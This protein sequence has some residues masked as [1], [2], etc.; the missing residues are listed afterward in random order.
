MLDNRNADS[1]LEDE[2]ATKVLAT[3][4]RLLK[5]D[6][7]GLDDNFFDSGGHSLLAM[8]LALELESELGLPVGLDRIFGRP[9]VRELCASL[10]ESVST[11]PARVLL[12]S[13]ARASH[14]IYFIHAAF[15][16]SALCEALSPD[17][18]TSFVTTNDRR[19]LRQL[20]ADNDVL[21]VLDAICDAYAAAILSTHKD[22]AMCLAGH[23]AG[24]IFAVETACKLEQRGVTVDSI[25]LFDTYLHSPIHRVV[26]DVLKNGSVMQKVQ[27]LLRVCG[28]G[29]FSVTGNSSRSSK[30]SAVQQA[31]T[32]SDM[33]FATL[34][35]QLREKTS[36]AYRGPMRRPACR[37]VLFRATKTV[38]GQT[39]RIDR[40]RGWARALEANLS[41]T[42]IAADHFNMVRGE[43]AQ[44]LAAKI[45]R[46]M[47]LP[48]N[49]IWSSEGDES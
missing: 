27:K 33:E 4:R 19:W 25:F 16:F 45:K 29:L 40:D 26:Y 48:T 39:R 31:S 24:G 1:L 3:C 8:V 28:H 5:N 22:G 17:I 20:M 35:S 30:V 14:T 43:Q 34:L 41:V 13:G 49:R 46:F 47:D 15:E 36:A 7:F 21:K 23:S 9:T 37:T 6:K 38:E 42:P 12:L 32:M 11:G 2:T 10:E 44:H 18:A